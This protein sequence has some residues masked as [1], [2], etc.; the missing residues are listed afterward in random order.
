MRS[1]WRAVTLG[2][3]VVLAVV[4]GADVASLSAQASDPR[5]GTWK[6]N[7][8][9]S[10]YSPGPAPQSQTLKIE[11]SGK[12]E[13]VTSEVVA[14]DGKRSTTTYTAN[15]DGKD[16]PLTGSAL[17]ADKLSL[18]RIDARTTE[19]TDKKDGKVV[20]TLRRVVSQDGKTMTVTG[21]GTNPEGKPINN[22]VVFEK[23]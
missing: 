18:K 8:A 6:L 22:V 5:V 12:G 10:K 15:F 23:Q 14:A 9:K 11:A 2:I 17:G 13:K 19:R 7:V 4:L 1:I 16:Y 21:K 20:L 3:V